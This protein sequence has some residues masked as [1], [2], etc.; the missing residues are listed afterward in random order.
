MALTGVAG[1]ILRTTAEDE[2]MARVTEIFIAGP[3]SLPSLT[4]R[5]VS[6][7]EGIHKAASP[8]RLRLE[9]LPAWVSV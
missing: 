9:S 4:G 6:R 2:F 7:D 1:T 8:R 3:I 5:A